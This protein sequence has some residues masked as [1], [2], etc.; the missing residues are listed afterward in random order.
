MELLLNLFWLML[1]LPA[2]W[3]WRVSRRR[4]EHRFTSLQ[5]LLALGC[6]LLILFPV[7]SAT[8]DLRAMR[9]EIEESPVGKRSLR[10]TNSDKASLWSSRPQTPPAILAATFSFELTSQP[11]ELVPVSSFLL[12]S[13]VVPHI[14]RAP[15][16]LPLT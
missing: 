2:C 12:P 15:P 8:D 4:P 10:L 9:S 7:I 6:A 3:I 16:S 13:A 1:A 11:S 5:C 14:G